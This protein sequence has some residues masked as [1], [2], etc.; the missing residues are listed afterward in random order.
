MNK[1]TAIQRVLNFFLTKII[2]GAATIVA[3]VALVEW[4]GKSA[5][6]KPGLTEDTKNLI[7]AIAEVVLVLSGYIFLLRV[8]EKRR[9]KELSAS[10]FVKN[11]VIG[12]MTGF[13][14]QALFIVVI[15]IVGT[16]S[17]VQVNPVSILVSPFAF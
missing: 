14:L 6:N 11:A 2:I 12:F 3:L 7:T 15:Y 1:Q 9:V 17:I 16:Y 13:G 4:L 8:Y 10:T 5:L